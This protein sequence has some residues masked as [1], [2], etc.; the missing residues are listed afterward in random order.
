VSNG[1]PSSSVWMGIRVEKK[2]CRFVST[3][4]VFDVVVTISVLMFHFVLSTPNGIQYSSCFV[5]VVF[6]VHIQDLLS[7]NDGDFAITSVDNPEMVG[8]RVVSVSVTIK[9]NGAHL[10][11]EYASEVGFILAFHVSTI[12]D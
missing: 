4:F 6:S 2:T 11:G 7:I 10:S 8:L 3:C 12:L 1:H 5:V 9:A